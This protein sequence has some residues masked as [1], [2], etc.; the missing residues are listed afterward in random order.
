APAR[1]DLTPG[2]PDLAAFPRA[3]WLRAERAVFADLPA[4]DL[5]YGDP[6]GA[7][8]LRTAVA[9]WVGRT[10]GIAV[11][12]EAVLVVS[13]TAQALGLL[14]EVLRAEGI[15]RVAVE[16]PGSMGVRQVLRGRGLATPPIPVDAE[17]ADIDALGAGGARAAL[18]TPA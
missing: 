12:P 16:N 9:G 10:R 6:R 17:G 8:A 18:L 7:A 13:G 15:D 3:A 11:D 1:V 4:A 5:G 2:T 14:A